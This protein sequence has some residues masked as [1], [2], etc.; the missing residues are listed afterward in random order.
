SAH[1]SG[2][3]SLPGARRMISLAGAQT[4]RRMTGLGG[5]GGPEGRLEAAPRRWPSSLE[6]PPARFAPSLEGA[7][8]R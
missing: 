1:A 3:L 8:V 7:A 2:Q 5:H 6:R 4:M